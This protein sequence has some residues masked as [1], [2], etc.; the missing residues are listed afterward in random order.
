MLY[1]EVLR[2]RYL[3]EQLLDRKG[4]KPLNVVHAPK[5]EKVLKEL[6]QPKVKPKR[7]RK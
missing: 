6:E 3:L 7:K 5:V 2:I 4:V 1:K